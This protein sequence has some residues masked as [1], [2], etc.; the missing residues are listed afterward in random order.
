MLIFLCCNGE[1]NPAIFKHSTKQQIKHRSN[2]ALYFY[3]CLIKT[4]PEVKLSP[5]L[6]ACKSNARLHQMNGILVRNSQE[7]RCCGW[8]EY[9]ECLLVFK[10][11]KTVHPHLHLNKDKTKTS[12]RTFHMC[13][14][15]N[16]FIL[17]LKTLSSHSINVLAT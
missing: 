7:R 17:V 11:D 12:Q 14:G 4:Y 15:R 5:T 1:N 9:E 8:K 10:R 13:T 6:N 2:E 3:F 16:I